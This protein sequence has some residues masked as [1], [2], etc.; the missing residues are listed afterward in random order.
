VRSEQAS[1]DGAAVVDGAVAVV[2]MRMPTDI[3]A[4]VIFE[5]TLVGSFAGCDYSIA[6]AHETNRDFDLISKV[7][8][9]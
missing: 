2:K 1:S 8:G 6:R 9:V 5:G 7:A 4:T 3:V